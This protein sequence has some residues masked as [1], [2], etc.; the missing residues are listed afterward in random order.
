M[1]ET[2]TTLPEILGVPLDE[3]VIDEILPASVCKPKR[4]RGAKP[5]LEV[6]RVA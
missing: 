2:T 3:T 6:R 5:L 1:S 4:E